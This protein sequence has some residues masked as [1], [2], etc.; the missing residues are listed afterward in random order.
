[1]WDGLCFYA[2]ALQIST[3]LRLLDR[4]VEVDSWSDEIDVL[5]DMSWYTILLTSKVVAAGFRV[6]VNVIFREK[7]V[8]GFFNGG[9]ELDPGKTLRHLNPLT[10]NPTL[11]KPRLDRG[12][13]VI[14]WGEC[15]FDL[16]LLARDQGNT[17]VCIVISNV[18][19][20]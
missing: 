11:H 6:G 10:L 4:C 13:C 14:G 2:T 15:F 1:V 12:N 7:E 18:H 17:G 16:L 3:F 9:I 8:F 20:E 5:A 19:P